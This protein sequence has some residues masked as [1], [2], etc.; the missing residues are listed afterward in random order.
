MESDEVDLPT[1]C[2]VTDAA[3]DCPPEFFGKVDV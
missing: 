3:N 1:E 2:T